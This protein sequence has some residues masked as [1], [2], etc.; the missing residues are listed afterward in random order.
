MYK[1]I[2]VKPI[3]RKTLPNTITYGVVETSNYGKILA[4]YYVEEKQLYICRFK[5]ALNTVGS[6]DIAIFIPCHRV[7]ARVNDMYKYG[8]GSDLKMKILLNEQK[9]K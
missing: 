3:I 8:S 1:N 4:A 2:I 7:K 5:F 9:R 6:N